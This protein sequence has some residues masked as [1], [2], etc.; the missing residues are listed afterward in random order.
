MKLF[1]SVCLLFTNY[2]KFFF[3]FQEVLSQCLG[4]HQHLGVVLFPHFP[5]FC[6]KIRRK[7]AKQMPNKGKMKKNSKKII[8][9]HLMQCAATVG[10]SK[11][12]TNNWAL[13]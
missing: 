2:N 4:V 6:I 7:L 13:V 5:P 10:C 3:N 9:D 12:K 8:F 1:S 11:Y